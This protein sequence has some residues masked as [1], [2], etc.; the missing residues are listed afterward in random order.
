MPCTPT[1]NL[2][3]AKSVSSASP[4]NPRKHLAQHLEEVAYLCRVFAT[5]A[6]GDRFSNIA[7]RI[8]LMHDLGKFH[9]EWQK[10]ISEISDHLDG[11]RPKRP[12]IVEHSRAGACRSLIAHG[13]GVVQRIS[14]LCIA[15]HH[16]GLIDA[17]NTDAVGRLQTDRTLI[18]RT[19]ESE[20][21]AEIAGFIQ[22]HP[23]A[24]GSYEKMPPGYKP[25]FCMRMLFSCLVD[26]DRL[27]S[28]VSEDAS[29]SIASLYRTEEDF[30]TVAQQFHQSLSK[31]FDTTSSHPVDEIRRE[32]F[33]YA[34]AA[35]SL[36]GNLFEMNAPSGCGKTVAGLA[37]AFEVAARRGLKRVIYA[38]PRITIA[39]QT[40]AIARSLIGGDRVIEHHSGSVAFAEVSESE[41][42]IASVSNWDGPMICT[43]IVQFFES[44][45]SSHGGAARKI[46]R[47]ANSVVIIDETQLIPRHL[48]SACIWVMNELMKNYRTV[49]VLATAT[50]PQLES[51][52]WY[53]GASAEF[54]QGKV[55]IVPNPDQLHYK[56]YAL[57]PIEIVF[58]TDPKHTEQIGKIIS[59]VCADGRSALVV[60]NTKR[61]AQNVY[62]YLSDEGKDVTFISS[63]LCSQH[64]LDVVERLK[65][66]SAYDESPYYVASTSIVDTGVDI[67]FPVVFREI[68]DHSDLIQSAGR[69][70][71]NGRSSRPGKFRVYISGRTKTD[72]LSGDMSHTRSMLLTYL[73][74]ARSEVGVMAGDSTY[75]PNEDF[76]SP[77]VIRQYN[78]QHRSHQDP[79]EQN[80]AR[81]LEY[82]PGNYETISRRFLLVDSDTLTVY[83][84]YKDEGRTVIAMLEAAEQHWKDAEQGLREPPKRGE[85]APL[86]RQA[87]R[88]S[89]QQYRNTVEQ[90][91]IRDDGFI[92]HL[93][94]LDVYVAVQ[95]DEDVYGLSWMSDPGNDR[96]I[97]FAPVVGVD[98]DE[99]P[100]V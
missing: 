1:K 72:H 83:V 69:A 10:Y 75:H 4:A 88:Y 11:K 77:S 66:R 84:P 56:M 54:S 52:A 27:V 79:D 57:R 78:T 100:Y 25:S 97:K 49:F 19:R 62:R 68:A 36:P 71:R 6:L 59:E 29:I 33:G 95:Y 64:V 46:H 92:R 32:L 99:I 31:N 67:D 30:S 34:V 81:E 9:P 94:L 89:S 76:V 35:A 82:F 98:V 22:A 7:F 23:E 41:R 17:R 63:D 38:A 26:A 48:H 87:Q 93:P 2:P 28:S 18:A 40:A 50:P 90:A 47:I 80:V 14:A 15:A 58:P 44:L 53:G 61:A 20:R 45:M 91:M 43:T 42:D 51:G 24:F 8:G 16:G 96:L 60:S 73:Q 70:N 85:Y 74:R 65:R 21:H 12:P 3:L 13:D 5:A 37:F 86:F 55:G 39:A